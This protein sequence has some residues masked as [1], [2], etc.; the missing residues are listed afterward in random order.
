[1]LVRPEVGDRRVL[2]GLLAQQQAGGRRLARL[3]GV[4]P[5]LHPDRLRVSRMVPPGHIAGRHHALH[6]PAVAPGSQPPVAANAVGHVQTGVGQPVGHGRHADADDDGVRR[7]NRP[8]A[9]SHRLGAPG[10]VLQHDL[11][12][13]DPGPQVGPFRA[14]PI[15]HGLADL[16]SE[17]PLQWDR[18]GL[19]HHGRDPDV[20]GAARHFQADEAGADDHQG[21]AAFQVGPQGNRVVEGAQVVHPGGGGRTGQEPGPGA[22][23]DH[24][25]VVGQVLAVEAHPP[26]IQVE[27]GGAPAEDPLDIEV[28]WNRQRRG[29]PPPPCRSGLAWTGEGGRTAGGARRR[30]W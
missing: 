2:L 26:A 13:P 29:P 1:M 11:V 19:Q 25:T 6:R 30:R 3:R 7:D 10:G 12:H 15:H 27:S 22:C 17:S 9:Q 20:L 5:V 24:Q 28:I 16:R 23:G 8:V 21:P 4:G 14:V 18:E